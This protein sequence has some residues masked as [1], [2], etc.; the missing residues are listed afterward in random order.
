MATAD[1]TRDK[2]DGAAERAQRDLT[3]S[4]GTSLTRPKSRRK[5]LFGLRRSRQSAGS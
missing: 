1:E 3:K 5:K 4:V 2:D